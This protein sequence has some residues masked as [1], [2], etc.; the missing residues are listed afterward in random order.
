M[1]LLIVALG[2]ALLLVLM[3]G[4]K[5]EGFISLVLVAIVV[6]L[7]NGLTL[8]DV[9]NSVEEGI[10]GQLGHLALIIGFGAM[11]GKLMADCGAAQRIAMTLTAKFGEKDCNGRF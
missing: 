9:V 8:S 2:V 1:P 11:L 7:L 6:G 4:F 5:L 3:V 10:G